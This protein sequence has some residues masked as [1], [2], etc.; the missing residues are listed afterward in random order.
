MRKLVFAIAAVVVLGWSGA[1]WA[2]LTTVSV[3]DKN[4]Q[5]VPN[6]TVTLTPHQT[7]T[8]RTS[9]KRTAAQGLHRKPVRLKAKTD[10]KGN[11]ILT[12]ND[13]D[14][15][16]GV[17]Y[18][19]Y[20]DAGRGARYKE[21]NVPLADM[22]TNQAVTVAA[23]AAAP[24]PT[25]P[26]AAPVVPVNVASVLGEGIEG[27]Q[28]HFGA[29]LGGVG[30]TG[31]PTHSS[32]GFYSGGLDHDA[33]GF[34]YGLSGFVDVARFGNSPAPFGSFVVSF[35]AVVDEVSR[36][37]IQWHG[38][39][40]GSPCDGTG[41]LS[42][43][44]AIGEIKVTT[45]IARGYTVNGYIGAGSATFFPS[46]TPTGPGGPMFDGS[47]TTYALRV[48]WGV[49]KQIDENWAI[50][51]KVGFQHTGDVEFDTSLP[52]ERFRFDHKNEVLFGFT[53]TYTPSSR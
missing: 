53:T 20:V 12:Y 30:V 44:N 11:M 3:K 31:L 52:G 7:S 36:A 37:S 48:G 50:G 14:L 22:V 33:L 16:A 45:P 27:P 42:E 49:D 5:P 51:T 18:D 41:H 24:A 4:G 13:D 34:V 26:T 8:K 47:A 35:G 15:K 10:D 23:V 32:S 9:P 29:F 38:A 25:A 2:V 39:C 46:G 43:F 21:R 40:G 6:A 19:V 1:A 17:I 28:F